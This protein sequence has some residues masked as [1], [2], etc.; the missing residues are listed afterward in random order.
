MTTVLP[1][2]PPPRP[3]ERVEVDDIARFT[4]R[5]DVRSPAEFADDHIPGAVNL[6][7]LDDAERAEVGKM[8]V[9]V[10]AFE[11]RKL[12][13]VLASRSIARMIE[14]YARDK[15][16]EWRPL[17]YCW[18]GGQR[19]RS[20]AHVLS[21]VGWRAAQL[22]GGYR[23]WRRHVVEQ[24]ASFPSRYAFRVVC[25]LTGSGKSR[26]LGSLAA[27][28][29]QVVD[30]EALARHRGSLL[31]DLPRDPQPGQKWFESQLYDAL[32][33]LDPGRPVYVESE[34]KRIGTVQLP[35][36][37]LDAMRAAAC[38]RVETPMP[39]RVALLKEEYAHFLDD[40]D[41]LEARLAHLVPLHGRKVVH[42]WSDLARAGDFDALVSELLSSHYDPLYL[43]SIERNF[44]RHGDAFVASVE[45]LDDA[46]LRSVARA[47]LASQPSHSDG[48]LLEAER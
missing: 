5:I 11:A 23:A 27:E 34:S 13:A 17:V 39:L 31:G 7:L 29:A 25:G 41:A 15:P 28:G 24:L 20:V 18:R 22:A 43:R 3:G 8:Y 40:R 30:L 47:I 44:P 42:R 1:P 21:E 9:Q 37:L 6:P 2:G 14:T 19:S 26:L 46:A 32:A 33:A 45:A 12:G 35:D 36:S 4:E 10:S 48:A 16:P 38:V